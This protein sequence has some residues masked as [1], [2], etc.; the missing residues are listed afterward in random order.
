M[1]CTLGGFV[2]LRLLS[3]H[4]LNYAV[5]QFDVL[6]IVKIETIVVHSLRISLI[7]GRRSFEFFCIVE[8]KSSLGTIARHG[9]TF[10]TFGRG[11]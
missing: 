9:L 7:F 6:S 8:T 3:L 4:R 10:M 5:G 11:R 2:R 1:F